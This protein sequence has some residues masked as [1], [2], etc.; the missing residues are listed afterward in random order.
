MPT[1]RARR[2]VHSRVLSEV[3]VRAAAPGFRAAGRPGPS[4]QALARD[5]YGCLS[6]MALECS[7]GH[8]RISGNGPQPDINYL[9][10]PDDRSSGRLPAG[11]GSAGPVMVTRV[12]RR[13][14]EV[15]TSP[16][17]WQATEPSPSS[18][19]L[20]GGVSVEQMSGLS[21]FRRS[22]QRVWNRQP[23]GGS[24]GLGTSPSSTMRWRVASAWVSGMGA[25]ESRAT[26]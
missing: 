1:A 15:R 2:T 11:D 14:E 10:P 12:S 25:A 13:S 8:V 6:G 26:V 9:F 19:G 17:K 21:S 3:V 20:K 16:G 23:A 22:Q 4:S 5:P 7:S 24:A 18:T